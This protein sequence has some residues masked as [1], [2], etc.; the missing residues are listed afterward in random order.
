MKT[1]QQLAQEYAAKEAK[2]RKSMLKGLA[3]IIGAKKKV[4][5]DC[6]NSIK[7]LEKTKD[8]AT[9]AVNEAVQMQNAF[10]Q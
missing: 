3:A 2:A 10:K 4:A 8:E 1:T 5:T 6:K 7:A 9:Q